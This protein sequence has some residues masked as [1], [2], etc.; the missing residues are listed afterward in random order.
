MAI[1]ERRD[2][3][4]QVRR[5][6]LRQDGA[7]LSDGQL[8]ECFLTRRDDAA[9]EALVRR[10]GAMVLGVCQRVLGDVHA[11]E[12]AFQATFLVLLRKAASVLPREQ[13]GHWLYGVAYRTALEARTMAIRRKSREQQ[14]AELPEP[15]AANEEPGQDWKPLLDRELS[16]LAD[17]YRM[18]IVL[19]DLEGRSRKD[20]A[21][22]L[23][24][25]EGTLSSR[26]ATGRRMLAQRLARHG[27]TLTAAG[28][29]ALLVENTASASVPATLLASTVRATKL[30][31]AGNAAKAV[32][33]APVAA[34]TEGVMRTMLLNRLKVI[35]P[36][37]LLVGLIGFAA[38]ALA[39]SGPEARPPRAPADP[40]QAKKDAPPDPELAEFY[41]KY[42]LLD[43]EVLK[44]IPEPY[45]DC[46]M[47]YYKKKH[48][49]QAENIPRGPAVMFFRAKADG[50]LYN[51]G[52]TF[53]DVNDGE[54]IQSMMRTLTGIYPQELDG[55]AEL[56]K[57]QIRGDFIVREGA[58]AEK[59]VARLQEI[60]QRECKLPVKLSFHEEER[61]VYVASGK[62]QPKPLEGRK[63]NEVD[64][65]GRQLVKDS[66]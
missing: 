28:L 27:L 47:I 34:L 63:N 23:A 4:H 15:P 19:C 43:G 42:A 52:M 1:G 40:P 46:R 45:P 24:I 49:H 50:T 18:A 10:H 21:Q 48:A 66:G 59:V 7:G 38:G 3:L 62:Y 60:L 5:A 25:P 35:A 64:I 26:L 36:V 8:L 57:K 17:K 58:P 31:L 6:A 16:R 2:V 12:D 22:Q 20:V 65:Y 44:F 13:V 39:R 61:K 41:K 11:A 54:A 51:W 33:P 29:A 14:V 37:V 9:F 55:D 53:C 56:L 32:V 30:I